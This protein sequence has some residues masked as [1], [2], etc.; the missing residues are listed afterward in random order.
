MASPN[1][2]A[3]ARV[4]TPEAGAVPFPGYQLVRLRGRG[5][6]ATV[7]ESTSPSGEMIALKFMST[8]S[9]GIAAKEIRSIQAI[10]ALDHPNLTRILQVWSMPGQIVIGMEL[11]DASLFDLMMLYHHDMGQHIDT[12]KLFGFMRQVAVALD[13]LNVR[14]HTAEGRLV[15]YQHADVK[16]NNLL[17][18]GDTVKLAD[19]GLAAATSG[20]QTPCPRQ[21]TAEYAAP[22]VFQG[23]L[24][25]SSD[26]FSLA[27]TY[28]LLRTGA[29]PYPPPPAPGAPKKSFVRPAPDLTL[30]PEPERPILGRALAAI[31]I[32]RF[33]TCGEFVAGLMVANG[34]PV[35]DGLVAKRKGASGVV[36]LALDAAAREAALAR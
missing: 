20:G 28:Y 2:N 25:E 29:F 21:G 10:Q 33:P 17:L 12:L 22:E 32:N 8:Q 3:A 1:R 36:Q 34:L 24:T 30:L 16:P 23:Y 18:F 31:P 19:Y 7:W 13:F 9:A 11:G 6:F 26:Q 27:V 35:P 5:G 4:F 15:G 14:Q